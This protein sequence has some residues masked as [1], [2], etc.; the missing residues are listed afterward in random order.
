M[1]LVEEGYSGSHSF[2]QRQWG[3]IKTGYSHFSNGD[4]GIAKISPCFEN[5]KSV[6]FNNLPNNIG[7]GTTELTVLRSL[8]V[9]SKFYLLLFKSDWYVSQ[10]T[11]EFKGVVGQQRVNKYIFTDLIVPVPPLEEQKR[12]VFE[13][14]KWFSL[15]AK[16]DESKHHINSTINM[17]KSKI[18]DLAIQGKLIPQ[19]PS[20]E[21]AIEL[22]KRINPDFKPCDNS[23]YENLPQGWTICRMGDVIR[24]ISGTSYDKSDVQDS[25]IKIL[26]GG[27]VQDG[28]ILERDDDVYVQMSRE[29]DECNV[30]IGD[31]V[32]VASTGSADL[33]GKAGYIRK[34]YKH[35]Q[36][37]AFLRIA[38][39]NIREMSPY[40][41]LIFSSE[42]YRSHIR[43]M[44]KGTNINN[45][46]AAYINDFA[47][48]LPPIAEQ[49]RIVA[50]VNKY[51]GI[52][53]EIKAAL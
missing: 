10:G 28:E 32:I 38:R 8:G 36:I 31:I 48:P 33:I 18:L 2:E 27:N 42:I 17:A 46:K 39:P 53:R 4:I 21:P 11:K 49:V 37:G 44:A 41:N 51:Y 30:R 13:V 15:I 20:D 50:T 35:T 7:S 24:L 16:L 9:Y 43:E 22:L 14:E 25:G 26:R 1:N 52:I 5:R 34:E 23:H 3:E 6:I 47:I 40:L 19:D 45:I 29:I 12:I